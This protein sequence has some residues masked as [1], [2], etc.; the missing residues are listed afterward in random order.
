MSHLLKE[1]YPKAHFRMSKATASVLM[2][3]I[4]IVEAC[5]GIRPSTS[6]TIH[7]LVK[8]ALTARGYDLTTQPGTT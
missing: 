1:S 7:A 5:T 8:E 6:N 3:H 4:D 2:K